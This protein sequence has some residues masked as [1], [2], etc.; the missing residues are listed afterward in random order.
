MKPLILMKIWWL[1]SSVKMIGIKRLF[2][3]RNNIVFKLDK[4]IQENYKKR[5]F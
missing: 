2:C 3:R 4:E 1:D 5:E